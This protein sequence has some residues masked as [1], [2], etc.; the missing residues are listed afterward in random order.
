MKIDLAPDPLLEQARN[1]LDEIKRTG[2]T[3]GPQFE[4]ARNEYLV[5]KQTHRQ[6]REQLP[7]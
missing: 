1:R 3:R 4:T 5:I 2:V 6:Q 7:M